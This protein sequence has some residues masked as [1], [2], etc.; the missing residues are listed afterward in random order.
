MEQF[1]TM[2]SGLISG[3]K[4]TFDVP[5]DGG[6]MPVLDTMCW[7]GIEDR[8]EGL[9]PDMLPDKYKNS[10]RVKTRSLKKLILYTFYKKPMANRNSN[11][12]SSAM[13]ESMKVS[14]TSNEI[15]RRMKNTSRD[16]PYP[17]LDRFL[18]NY[19]D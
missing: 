3:L 2:A 5:P 11:R 17:I 14:M 13:P 9:N 1:S 15:Q 7:M 8:E 12:Q 6:G 19:M 18:T 10:R 4:F 16:L